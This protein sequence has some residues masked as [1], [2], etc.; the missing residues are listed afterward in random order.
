VL[1]EE[2]VAYVL[3]VGFGDPAAFALGVEAC[4]EV[5][6]DFCYEGFEAGIPA[7]FF[8]VDY[9]FAM[10]DPAY[11]AGAVGAQGDS[12]R[13]HVGWSRIFG[14]KA[15]AKERTQGLGSSFKLA[16]CELTA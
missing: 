13:V 14:E 15:K 8:G 1:D 10:D 6:G 11:V 5:G 4:E 3:A 7:V 16:S 2:D 9:G 12:L